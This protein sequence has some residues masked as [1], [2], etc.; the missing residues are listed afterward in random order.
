MPREPKRLRFET[1]HIVTCRKW[2]LKRYSVQF[3]SDLSVDNSEACYI[4]VTTT[5]CTADHLDMSSLFQTLETCS[6]LGR[7]TF[8][9][10]A[11]KTALWI[12][13]LWSIMHQQKVTEIQ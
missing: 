12:W 7:M 2:I 11:D 9:Q 4:I 6:F 13:T 8:E 1:S 10:V 3:V 5:L